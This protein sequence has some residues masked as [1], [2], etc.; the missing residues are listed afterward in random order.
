MCMDVRVCVCMCDD[1]AGVCNCGCVDVVVCLR[2]F[3]CLR[4]YAYAQVHVYACARAHD[5]SRVIM[6]ISSTSETGRRGVSGGSVLRCFGA[7]EQ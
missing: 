5:R 2:V 7:V 3:V 4:V 6:F 1:G